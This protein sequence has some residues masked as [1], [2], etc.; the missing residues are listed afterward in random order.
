NGQIIY[1]QITNSEANTVFLGEYDFAKLD[2]DHLL[3]II[4][5]ISEDKLAFLQEKHV[6]NKKAGKIGIEKCA[7]MGLGAAY[8]RLMEEGKLA[9]NFVNQVKML[10][11]GAV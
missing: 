9:N 7:G 8:K 11:A 1:R 6:L 5:N 2:F 3:E 4:G 10:V